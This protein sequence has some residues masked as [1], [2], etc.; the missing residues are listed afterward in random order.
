MKFCVWIYFW[1]SFLAMVK[2]MLLKNDHLHS[3][4]LLIWT[5][6]VVV[7]DVETAPDTVK[8]AILE[9]L[10]LKFFFDS[11]PLGNFLVFYENQNAI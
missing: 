5:V 11:Q 4:N 2:C 7:F 9:Q 10:E 8:L 1:K 3:L 6:C